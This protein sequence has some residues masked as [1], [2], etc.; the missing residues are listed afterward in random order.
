MLN[1]SYDGKLG[2]AVSALFPEIGFNIAK[3][4]ETHGMRA[5]QKKKRRKGI[6]SKVFNLFVGTSK[7]ATV[8]RLLL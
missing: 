4:K 1:Q 8:T 7:S 2:T 5:E 6:V 3:F